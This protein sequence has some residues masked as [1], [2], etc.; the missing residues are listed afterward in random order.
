MS[1]H[2]CTLS[3]WQEVPRWAR[4]KSLS[5]SRFPKAPPRHHQLTRGVNIGEI[6]VKVR[7][8]GVKVWFSIPFWQG[9][10]RFTIREQPLN[11]LGS[12]LFC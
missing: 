1:K 7:G 2:P 11:R 3:L 8:S 9:K 10:E 12:R 4:R 6:L 5:E